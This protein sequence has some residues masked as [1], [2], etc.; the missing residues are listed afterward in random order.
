MLDR[1]LKIVLVI[2]LIILG[3]SF[4]DA[5]T[6]YEISD[7]LKG[8]WSGLLILVTLLTIAGFWTFRFKKTPFE[9]RFL[10]IFTPAVM[11]LLIL[12]IGNNIGLLTKN[13]GLECDVIFALAF[14]N[15]LI[16]AFLLF[17]FRKHKILYISIVGISVLMFLISLYLAIGFAFG[18][19]GE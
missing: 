13:I 12:V 16:G 6:I 3:I 10:W 19:G 5:R 7:M 9:L 8:G 2:A 4:L 14:L 17:C 15:L 11:P 18:M 1:V